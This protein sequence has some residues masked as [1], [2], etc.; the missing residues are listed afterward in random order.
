MAESRSFAQARRFGRLWASR[1]VRLVV[2]LAA[3]VVLG[4]FAWRMA[5]ILFQGLESD[6]SA[7]N[8]LS[9]ASGTV[10]G[11]TISL[12]KR[13][14]LALESLGKWIAGSAC[15]GSASHLVA[16]CVTLPLALFAI[17]FCLALVPR[18]L[19]Q[20]GEIS[21]EQR[22]KNA[23]AEHGYTTMRADLLDNLAMLEPPSTSEDRFRIPILFERGQLPERGETDLAL[24]ENLSD[25]GFSSGL[26]YARVQDRDLIRRLVSG[27]A[28]C[29]AA[30]GFSPVRLRVEGYAS[31]EP[32]E[33]VAADVSRR[34]NVQL[35]NE[36][37][38]VVERD[39]RAEIGRLGARIRLVEVPDYTE[40]S[41][42]ERS[43]RFNDRPGD[44]PARGDY[45][46]DFF[47]RAA[48]IRVLE[49]AGCEYE[50]P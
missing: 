23:M 35:A 9:I 27:L 45:G 38:R 49:L 29:A 4:V 25:V 34:L 14:S 18:L 17:V 46:Q 26:D 44:S 43:R 12:I 5:T 20:N 28:P 3:L 22:M 21:L 10:F 47:T 7:L 1:A 15:R 19:S 48:Y 42:M 41:A 2:S 40:I 13:V 33:R 50:G 8:L 30:E 11:V 39:L 6:K 32:F 16:F 24:P 31:S 37:R 36:R